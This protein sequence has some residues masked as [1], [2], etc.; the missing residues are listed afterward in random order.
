MAAIHHEGLSLSELLNGIA[1]VDINRDIKITGLEL[2]SRNVHQGDCFLAITGASVQGIDFIPDAFSK[3]AVVVLVDSNDRLLI[4]KARQWNVIFVDQLTAKIGEMAH[5]Y[6]GQPTDFMKMFGVTGTNGKTSVGHFIGQAIDKI[7]GKGTC[8]VIGTLGNGLLGELVSTGMTTPDAIRM[9]RTLSR[10]RDQGAQVSVVEASSHGLSQHRLG[11]IA[12][13]VAVFTN[14]T[15]DH[16]DYHGDM[17]SYGAAKLELFKSPNLQATVINLDDPFCEQILEV[18]A[19]RGSDDV[20]VVGY[21]LRS[22]VSYPGMKIIRC[23]KLAVSVRGLNMEIDTPEGSNVLKTHLLGRFNAS[24]LL[25]ALGAL[26]TCGFRFQE[27]LDALSEVAGVPGRMEAFVQ[28]TSAPVVVD[29]A[30]T[31]DG[32]SKA[33]ETLR[34]VC[35]ENIWCVFGCGGERDAGKRALMGEIAEKLADSI[36]V[37][38]DNPRSED[39]SVI[40]SSILSGMDKPARAKVILDRKLAIETA[41]NSAKP[42]DIILIAGKGHEDWQEINGHRFPFNDRNVVLNILGEE[43]QDD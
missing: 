26:M 21:S 5:R 18:L 37:T 35:A 25:A 7:S 36:I 43:K 39:P 19:R 17:S 38:N 10:L 1:V 23:S 29:F 11:G 13:D 22:D 31:P 20:E 6:Y 4:T 42:E 15:R 24:N 32:L 14:L 2:D 40:A 27:A 8:G 33:L 16:L 9:H 34:E 12:F 30:H 28:G 3:G 41:I